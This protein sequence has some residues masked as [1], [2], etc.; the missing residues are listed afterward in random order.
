M[1]HGVEPAALEPVHQFARRH[2]IG[3]LALGEISPLAVMA[4]EIANDDIGA[5]GFVERRHDIRSDEARA[6]GDKKH[7]SVRLLGVT[8]ASAARASNLRGPAW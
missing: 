5:A 7:E 2:E 1:N 8:N 6:A 3:E 4:E